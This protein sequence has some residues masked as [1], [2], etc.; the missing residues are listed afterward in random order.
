[1]LR[2][3]PRTPAIPPVVVDPRF[4]GSFELAGT[5]QRRGVLYWAALLARRRAT[6][7]CCIA[8][9]A[10]CARGPSCCSRCSNPRSRRARVKSGIPC[11]VGGRPPPGARWYRTRSMLDLMRLAAAGMTCLPTVPVPHASRAG[12]PP[13]RHSA[14]ARRARAFADACG[15]AL[16][17]AG[18]YI[19][20]RGRCEQAVVHLRCSRNANCRTRLPVGARAHH[21]GDGRR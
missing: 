21:S 6:A 20:A 5:L 14:S 12:A 18:I 1:V 15:G 2:C 16:P 8:T 7:S 9:A 10:S 11:S 4:E 17:D 3:A 19:G 13:D